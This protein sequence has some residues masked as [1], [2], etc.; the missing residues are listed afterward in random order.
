MKNGF[1]IGLIWFVVLGGVP[2]YASSISHGISPWIAGYLGITAVSAICVTTA[3]RLA[4][5]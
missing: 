2:A 5:K 1:L 4:Q 3:V